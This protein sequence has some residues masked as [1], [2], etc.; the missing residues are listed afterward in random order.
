MLLSPMTNCPDEPRHL[1]HLRG[2]HK[3]SWGTVFFFRTPGG[4]G[5]SASPWGLG[6]W[7]EQGPRVKG[8][9]AP[10]LRKLGFVEGAR[11]PQ[12]YPFRTT[13]QKGSFAGARAAWEFAAK[14]CFK[15]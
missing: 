13:V 5:G 14:K 9:S 4:K 12:K 6:C 1:I 2:G 3:G 7:G 15:L 11:R 10:P 8:G